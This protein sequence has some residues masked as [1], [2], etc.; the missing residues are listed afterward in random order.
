MKVTEILESPQEFIQKKV[1]IEGLLMATRNHIY[2]AID[3]E[4]SRNLQSAIL[5]EDQESFMDKLDN[6]DI[7]PWGGSDVTYRESVLAEGIFCRSEHEKFPFS[8]REISTAII[9]MDGEKH[10]II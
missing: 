3:E 1:K 2:I 10:Q 6:S 5:I 7:P 9:E 4:N 8:L